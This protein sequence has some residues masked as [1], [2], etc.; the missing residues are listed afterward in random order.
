[1]GDCERDTIG[2]L[3]E[4]GKWSYG[5]NNAGLDI[6]SSM[7]H[8][9]QWVQPAS[10]KFSPMITDDEVMLVDSAVAALKQKNRRLY[11]I[12]VWYFVFNEGLREI[13][14][15]LQCSRDCAGKDFKFAC[16]WIEGRMD[17]AQQTIFD[18]A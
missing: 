5:G 16:G 4:W 2:L 6:N 3:V 1:M 18:A 17:G 14:E 7:L 12:I 11:N 10:S 9:M 15:K 13:A 8:V